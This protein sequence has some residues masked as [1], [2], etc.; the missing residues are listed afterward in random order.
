MSGMVNHP[1]SPRRCAA[2]IMTV[3]FTSLHYSSALLRASSFVNCGREKQDVR[4]K[5]DTNFQ[6]R[7]SEHFELRISN[8]YLSYLPHFSHKSCAITEKRFT[9][10]APLPPSI[11]EEGEGGG[12]RTVMNNAGSYSARAVEALIFGY[13]PPVK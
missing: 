5:R 10:S 2:S 13:C 6:F 7:S 11:M 4:D 12:R 1:V 9:R 3:T 8:R